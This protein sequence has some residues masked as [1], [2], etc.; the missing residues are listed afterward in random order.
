MPATLGNVDPIAQINDLIAR[1]AGGGPGPV[2]LPFTEI[3]DHGPAGGR[4]RVRRRPPDCP[5]L[6]GSELRLDPTDAL[7]VSRHVGPAHPV[8]TMVAIALRRAAG[9]RPVRR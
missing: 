4:S 5:L 7:A 1:S 8:S 9:D 2:R 3:W 6:S